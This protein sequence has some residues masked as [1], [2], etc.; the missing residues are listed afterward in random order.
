MDSELEAI[1]EIGRTAS[2]DE[3]GGL[4]RVLRLATRFLQ[5]PLVLVALTDAGAPRGFT[6]VAVSSGSDDTGGDASAITASS[7]FQELHTALLGAVLPSVTHE[8]FG[9]RS[10]LGFPLST[11][12]HGSLGTFWVFASGI[13]SWEPGEVECLQALGETLEAEISLRRTLHHQMRHQLPPPAV[14]ADMRFQA[15][16]RAAAFQ[17]LGQRLNTV[18]TPREA[19]EI[20]LAAADQLVGWDSCWLDLCDFD[21]RQSRS[22]LLMDVIDGV[23]QEVMPTDVQLTERNLSWRAAHE[24]A[25]RVLLSEAALLAAEDELR[26]FGDLTRRS[27]SVLCAPIRYGGRVFGALSVQ[28]YIRN[29]YTETDLETL[30]ALADYCAGALQRTMAEAERRTLQNQLLQSQKLEAV[31]RLAGGVAHDFNNMLAVINGYAE[32]LLMRWSPE[33]PD[34]P[35]VEEI[36]K[37]GQRAAGLTQQ[38]L[39]FSRKQVT[40]PRPLDLAEVVTQL[41][42]M[43]QRLTGKA[44]DLVTQ[45]EAEA[46]RV[47]ADPAQLDQLLV[48]LAM[49]ARDAMPQGGTLT[50]WVRRAELA[51]PAAGYPDEV[52]VGRY[53]LLEVGDTGCGI[54]PDTLNHVFEPFF[55]TKPVGQGPGLGLATVHGILK[56]SGGFIQ[57]RSEPGVGT[58]FCLYL[59]ALA[60][61]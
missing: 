47:K 51:R 5:A 52:P 42:P 49:N 17:A 41:Q 54:H 44:V 22:V 14:T 39:A 43:L 25:F 1:L 29:A 4:R 13:R 28:S 34:R 59:P 37:A 3:E 55:T 45:F 48:N 11:G 23:R 56:Q 31:G 36:L 38:L 50:L 30:Q 57:V 61:A 58:N 60:D 24:G 7:R 27:A 46:G 21:T 8:T 40:A 12:N 26:S 53:V 16:A 32:L 2:A 9:T 6:V 18:A 15:E 10:A 35:P 20:V 33:A 19:A